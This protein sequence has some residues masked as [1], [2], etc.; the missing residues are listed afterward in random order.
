M[1]REIVPIPRRDLGRAGLEKLPATIAR[2]GEKAA[3][4]LIE[5]FAVNIRDQHTR[6]ANLDFGIRAN[7]T[8]SF[9]R[10]VLAILGGSAF[11]SFLFS[12]CGGVKLENSD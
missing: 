4:R 7:P 3:W 9:V 10:A 8:S 12:I 2:A 6:Q 5:F 11:L 1:T